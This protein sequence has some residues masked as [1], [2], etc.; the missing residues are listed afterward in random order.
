[1]RRNGIWTRGFADSEDFVVEGRVGGSVVAEDD[2]GSA[3]RRRERRET[4]GSASERRREG[5]RW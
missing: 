4:G 2:V 1:V 5:R 3:W